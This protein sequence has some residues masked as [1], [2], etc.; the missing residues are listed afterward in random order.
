MCALC[1][2]LSSQAAGSKSQRY[3]CAVVYKCA[4]RYGD[5]EF[6]NAMLQQNA[7]AYALNA[8]Q[9]QGIFNMRKRDQG[10]VDGEHAQEHEYWLKRR[11]HGTSQAALGGSRW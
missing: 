1:R 8:L 2:D 10:Y 7:V 3:C 9:R 4:R 11:I 5:F 6:E